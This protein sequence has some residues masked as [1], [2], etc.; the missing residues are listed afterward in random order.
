MTPREKRRYIRYQ[1]TSALVSSPYA[2]FV[3]TSGESRCRLLVLVCKQGGKRT[4]TLQA[5]TRAGS[6]CVHMLTPAPN[7]N[8]IFISV[9]VDSEVYDF[10]NVERTLVVELEDAAGALGY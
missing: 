1:S 3:V 2:P 5:T 10:R 7:N 6:R 9:S 8:K 4:E